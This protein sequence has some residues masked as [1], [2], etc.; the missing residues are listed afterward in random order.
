MN[1]ATTGDKL[2]INKLCI[3]SQAIHTRVGFFFPNKKR[4]K[5]KKSRS[6][7]GSRI[8]DYRWYSDRIQK[9]K[10]TSL[11]KRDSIS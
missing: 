10:S 4:Q 2:E 1:D 11:L 6:C 8:Y 7:N 3:S 5:R 9:L